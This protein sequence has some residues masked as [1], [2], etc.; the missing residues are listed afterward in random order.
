MRQPADISRPQD[1]PPPPRKP[2]TG[3]VSAH[4]RSTQLIPTNPIH[5]V[6]YAPASGQ[7]VTAPKLT[8]PKRHDQRNDRS[9]YHSHETPK[10]HGQRLIHPTLPSV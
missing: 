5:A 4:G 7:F 3:I 6:L 2:V 8:A 10:Q 9:C 1:R